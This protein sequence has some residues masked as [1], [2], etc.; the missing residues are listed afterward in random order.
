LIL[1]SL[2]FA[3]IMY[4]HDAVIISITTPLLIPAVTQFCLI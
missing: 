3:W 4:T 1:A 2:L